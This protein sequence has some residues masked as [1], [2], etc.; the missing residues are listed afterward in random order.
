MQH[1][2]DSVGNYSRLGVELFVYFC[3]YGVVLPPPTP[4]P[5]PS[6]PLLVSH[7]SYVYLYMP[8]CV[9]TGAPKR[10][11]GGGRGLGTLELYYYSTTLQRLNPKS[12]RKL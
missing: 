12:E 7:L 9:F 2:A 5:P 10:L 1:H 3:T 8:T 11:G 6:E 4:P